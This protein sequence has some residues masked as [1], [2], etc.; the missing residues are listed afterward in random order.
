MTLVLANSDQVLK[1]KGNNEEHEKKKSQ[2]TQ[3]SGPSKLYNMF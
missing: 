1:N 2:D 3:Q